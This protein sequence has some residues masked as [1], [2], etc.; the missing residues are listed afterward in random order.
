VPG[1]RPTIALC[2]N[3][4]PIYVQSE[5]DDLLLPDNPDLIEDIYVYGINHKL[6]AEVSFKVVLARINVGSIN[7]TPELYANIKTLIGLFQNYTN[8]TVIESSTGNCVNLLQ[9]KTTT[10]FILYA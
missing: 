2:A 8:L 5:G 4:K 7:I 9:V 10:G 3:Y 1:F 6:N